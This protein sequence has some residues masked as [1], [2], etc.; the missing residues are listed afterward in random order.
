MRPSASTVKRLFAK[1]SDRCA[2]PRCV[3]SLT[4]GETLIGEICHIKGDK[5]GSPRYDSGQS[6]EDRQSYDNLIILCPNHHTVID[7]DEDAYTVTRLQKMKFNH[8]QSSAALPDDKTESVVKNFIQQEVKTVGQSGG[9][10]AHTVHAH[11]INLGSNSSIDITSQR[12]LLAVETLWQ[13]IRNM[14]GAFGDIVFVETILLPEEIEKAFVTDSWHASFGHLRNYRNERAIIEK[15]KETKASVME[16]ERPFVSPRLWTAAF[17]IRAV[18]GR[19]AFLYQNSYKSQQYRDWR[20]D[21][22]I[23]QLLR[24]ALPAA[25][26]DQVKNTPLH[27]LQNAINALE[28]KFLTEAKLQRV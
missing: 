6:D 15:L 3:A 8:E 19:L 1:S 26:V 28:N 12:Q 2:F 18:Y 20:K 25:I 24:S 22:G 23:E 21:S 7:D 11:T 4:Y 17:V 27:G 9:L 13:T 5:P 10:A 14:A 16:L